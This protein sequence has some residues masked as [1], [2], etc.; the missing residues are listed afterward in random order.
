M[1]LFI[2]TKYFVSINIEYF[3]D[4]QKVAKKFR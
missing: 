2:D 1:T 3:L 4:Y